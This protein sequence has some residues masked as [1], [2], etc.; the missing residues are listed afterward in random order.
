MD[1]ITLQP[2]NFPF[3]AEYCHTA[4]GEL[5]LTGD[6]SALAALLGFLPQELSGKQLGDLI[7]ADEK[8]KILCQLSGQIR[9]DKEIDLFIPLLKKDGSTLGVLDR[10]SP[11]VAQDG[12]RLIRGAMIAADNS[13]R[14]ICRQREA[15]ETYKVKLQQT[16]SMMNSFQMRAEQDS[17]TGLF[18]AMTTRDLCEEYFSDAPQSCAMIMIDVDNFKRINDLFG[19]MVGD[20][21]LT[22]A[23][24][25]IKRLFRSNDIVGRVGGDEFLVLMKD[26]ADRNI[27]EL[28]CS[29]IV[30]AFNEILCEEKNNL[31]LGC[32]VGA[33]IACTCGETYDS[34]FRRADQLMYQCKRSG[35]NR[36]IVE[37]KL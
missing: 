15:L 9:S 21:M 4:D 8:G 20:A 33:T 37:S 30:A 36:Y 12:T 11:V 3:L 27:V 35:G 18:N 19:H 28:R 5:T 7:P 13:Y 14:Q 22:R 24:A 16:E 29:Q 6:C 32:S 10:G 34:L 31:H 2:F 26:V 25:V 17:L 1:A 23:T